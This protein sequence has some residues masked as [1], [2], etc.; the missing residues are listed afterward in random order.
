MAP[1]GGAPGGVTV[2]GMHEEEDPGTWETHPHGEDPGGRRQGRPEPRPKARWESEGSIGAK[3][4]G[5]GDADLVEQREPAL[6]R[7]SKGNHE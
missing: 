5:N 7:A 3:T 2:A 4:R 6:E 1:E